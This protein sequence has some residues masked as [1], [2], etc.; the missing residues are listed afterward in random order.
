MPA[1]PEWEELE[2]ELLKKADVVV[3]KTN[4]YVSK[5]FSFDYG[6]PTHTEKQLYKSLWEK[7]WY[8]IY[9]R[10]YGI[11]YDKYMHSA[12]IEMYTSKY[13]RYYA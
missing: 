2:N 10:I 8:K 6:V 11:I 7:A 5:E 1:D 12:Q 13:E 3:N 9:G 4:Q